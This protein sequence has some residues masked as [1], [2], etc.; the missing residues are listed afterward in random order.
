[1]K[2]SPLTFAT[3]ALAAL[4]L[5]A[6]PG[7]PGLAGDDEREPPRR[8]DDDA[9][10]RVY[11][12]AD[13]EKYGPPSPVEPREEE[14]WT[15]V[16]EFIERERAEIASRR[17]YELER[18]RVEQEGEAL[19]PEPEPRYVFPYP[20]VR[21]PWL[22]PRLGGNLHRPG[23][24][25]GDGPR[26]EPTF[27]EEYFSPIRPLHARPAPGSGSGPGSRAGGPER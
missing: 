7:S 20:I 26:R 14:D 11:T 8:D 13:L 6:L 21:A 27:R 4:A 24:P 3:R 15:F 10:V 17:A 22:K 25:P 18:L 1:M 23:R 12:N 19:A 16:Q 2:R 5:A 9:E